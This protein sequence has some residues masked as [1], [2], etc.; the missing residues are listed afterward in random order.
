MQIS[1]AIQYGFGLGPEYPITQKESIPGRYQ[2]SC[3]SLRNLLVDGYQFNTMPE[4]EQVTYELFE[5]YVYY[6]LYD[7][8]NDVSLKQ[9]NSRIKRK[10]KR[11]TTA[12]IIDEYGIGEYEGIQLY[13][14][15]SKQVNNKCGIVAEIFKEKQDAVFY[16]P[17]KHKKLP[18]GRV[19]RIRRGVK[20]FL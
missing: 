17:E 2:I 1:W 5:K 9:L 16:I 3:F 18:I 11:S 6:L 13:K 15:S 7:L 19:L 20:L 12:L 10:K 14:L 8:C 4:N